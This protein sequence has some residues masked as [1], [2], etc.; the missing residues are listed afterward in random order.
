MVD[1]TTYMFTNFEAGKYKKWVVWKL[2]SK[3]KRRKRVFAIDC[4]EIFIYHTGSL[5]MCGGCMSGNETYIFISSIVDVQL[6]ENHPD[7]FVLFYHDDDYDSDDSDA[8][9]SSDDRK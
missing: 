5:K 3:G 6:D 9:L 1:V 7:V 8:N 2:T 4:D